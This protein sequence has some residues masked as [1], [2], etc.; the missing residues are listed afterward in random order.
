MNNENLTDSICKFGLLKNALVVLCDYIASFD[1]YLG[2]EPCAD[3]PAPMMFNWRRLNDY[4]ESAAAL[5][6]A[7]IGG[8][9][10]K[11]KSAA[12]EFG[13]V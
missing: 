3:A 13:G 11:I 9:S 12:A 7:K 2:V 8:G 5:R 6:L 1:S 4:F 10:V